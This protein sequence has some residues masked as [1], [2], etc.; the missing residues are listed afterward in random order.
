ML[1]FVSKFNFFCIKRS[2]FNYVIENF[3]FKKNLSKNLLKVTH[4]FNFYFCKLD[5][6]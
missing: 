2:L 5:T 4:N 6:N 1:L 3:S